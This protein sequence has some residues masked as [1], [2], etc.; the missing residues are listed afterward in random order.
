MT[1][2]FAKHGKGITFAGIFADPPVA[3]PNRNFFSKGGTV[4]WR[5]HLPYLKDSKILMQNG[6]D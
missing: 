1:F 3:I 4:L 2:F 5:G 6:F